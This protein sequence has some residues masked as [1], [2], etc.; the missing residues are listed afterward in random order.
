ME[1][2]IYRAQ[3]TGGAVANLH[4]VSVHRNGGRVYLSPRLCEEL[5]VMTGHRLLLAQDGERGGWYMAFGDSEG[6]DG[7]VRLR[8]NAKTPEARERTRALTGGNRQAAGKILD[9]V[10]ADRSAVF[11]VDLRPKEQ[12]GMKWYQ[13]LTRRPVRKDNIYENL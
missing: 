5:D 7:G 2:K 8:K 13:I 11:L 4:Y 9:E 12:D 6:F 3:A 1:L 10:D